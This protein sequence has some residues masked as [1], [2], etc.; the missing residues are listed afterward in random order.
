[1]LSCQ[2]QINKIIKK[3]EDEIHKGGRIAI[4]INLIIIFLPRQ[5]NLCVY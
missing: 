5:T 3:I 1:M 4:P 2:K